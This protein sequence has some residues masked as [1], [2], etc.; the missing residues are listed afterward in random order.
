MSTQHN[1]HSFTVF[2]QRLF[3]VMIVLLSATTLPVGCWADTHEVGIIEDYFSATYPEARNEF[4]AAAEAAGGTIESFRNP[5]LGAEGEALYTDVALFN[6]ENAN[7]I[8]VL[9]SGTHGVEGFAGSGIQVGLL[10]NGI[11]DTLPK[12]VGLL[13]YHALNPYG[14]S[15]LRRFNEDNVDLNRNFVN[16]SEPHPTNETYDQLAGLIEPSSL[17]VWQTF[18]AKL[19]FAWYGVTKG[20]LWLKTAI[21]QGQYNHPQGLFFGGKA[22]TWSNRLLQGIIQ[23]HLTTASRVV[24]IDFHTGLG[25]YG[26]AEVLIREGP[27][28]AAFERAV[29]WWGDRVKSR[30]GGESF[31]HPIKGSVKSAFTRTLPKTEITAVSLEFGTSPAAEV[32]LAL[33]AEN[34]LHHHSTAGNLNAGAIKDELRRVFYPDTDDWKRMAW[35]QGRDVVTLVLRNMH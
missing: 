26:D 29:L 35:K 3:T 25:E 14:F 18:K 1:G 23:R 24:L 4:I 21:S 12:G 27:G 34:Y 13:C 22:E 8:L 15:H 5:N 32:F 20:K 2:S 17:S 28:D 6:L 30:K 11:A 33:R 19:V 9:G 10:R 31:P 16:H 7:S